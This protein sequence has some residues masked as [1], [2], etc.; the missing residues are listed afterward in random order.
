MLLMV[1]A[2]AWAAYL[3]PPIFRWLKR[4]QFGLRRRSTF[5]RLG[6][7]GGSTSLLRPISP[8]PMSPRLAERGAMV[9]PVVALRPNSGAANPSY[10][11]PVATPTQQ[12]FYQSSIRARHRRR[13]VLVMLIG[14]VLVSFVLA[15]YFGGIALL[16]HL[17]IDAILLAYAMA[18][19]QHQRMREERL[20]P[21]DVGQMHTEPSRSG[22]DLWGTASGS[23]N[24]P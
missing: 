15:I 11:A 18:L 6:S 19:V 12:M 20:K 5:R 14:A 10:T 4:G 3:I 2:A 24:R 16:V 17:L 8:R 1:L 23:Q 9:A 7:T 22:A 13:R 21:I